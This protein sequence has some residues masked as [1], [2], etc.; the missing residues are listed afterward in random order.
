[1]FN[2]RHLLP[3]A[4]L[5]AVLSYAVP[6]SAETIIDEWAKVQVPSPPELKSSEDQ[7]DSSSA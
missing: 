6:S 2:V 1:M 3:L 5:A 4:A 7:R